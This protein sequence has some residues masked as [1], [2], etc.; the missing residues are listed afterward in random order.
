MSFDAEVSQIV[1]VEFGLR[2]CALPRRA[3]KWEANMSLWWRCRDRYRPAVLCRVMT[4]E[5]LIVHSGQ[6][7]GQL[8]EINGRDRELAVPMLDPPTCARFVAQ[9]R[10]KLKD[11]TLSVCRFSALSENWIV[12][13][14]AGLPAIE[15]LSEAEALVRLYEDQFPAR[16]RRMVP[17]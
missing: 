9:L 16:K 11:E 8:A 13:G 5:A 10:R 12:D 15:G 1:P 14:K 4:S 17:A 6:R 2:M 3:W 7:E